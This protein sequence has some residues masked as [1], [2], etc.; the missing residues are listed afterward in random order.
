MKVNS[1]LKAFTSV[2]I[3]APLNT[4]TKGHYMIWEFS[5]Y[6]LTHKSQPFSMPDRVEI[7]T[8]LLQTFYDICAVYLF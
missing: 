3:H 2:S 8:G 1:W 5:N 4:E 7:F 6:V